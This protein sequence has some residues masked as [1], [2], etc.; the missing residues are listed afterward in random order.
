MLISCNL[1]L[2]ARPLGTLRIPLWLPLPFK[3]L[4]INFIGEFIDQSP[5][6]FPEFNTDVHV[7]VLDLTSLCT[8]NRIVTNVFVT[9][10]L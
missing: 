3:D 10:P 8:N 9:S 5:G 1:E 2:R 6:L 7:L 4:N